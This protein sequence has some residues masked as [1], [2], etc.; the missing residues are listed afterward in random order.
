MIKISRTW[1]QAGRGGDHDADCGCEWEGK[2]PE[3]H[4]G[5]AA[6][7]VVGQ[8]EGQRP[9]CRPD[10][11]R[12]EG[13]TANAAEVAPTEARGPGCVERDRLQPE[14]QPAQHP[15]G[16]G[17][18][19]RIGNQEPDQSGHKEELSGCQDIPAREAVN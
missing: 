10:D 7:Q 3:D 14:R 4:G 11:L 6:K 19:Q 1:G 2:H 18:E 13:D 15:V 17:M 5:V 8:S 12:P 16:D 9:E